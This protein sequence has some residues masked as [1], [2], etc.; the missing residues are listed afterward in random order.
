MLTKFVILN[1]ILDEVR[2]QKAFSRPRVAM[3]QKPT[4]SL[5]RL[6]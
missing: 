5:E 3:E 6:L 4:L 1:T 2:S